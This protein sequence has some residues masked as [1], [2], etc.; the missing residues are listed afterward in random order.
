MPKE[1]LKSAILWLIK[2]PLL[3][4]SR[5]YRNSS[6]SPEIAVN[7]WRFYIGICLFYYE[8]IRTPFAEPFKAGALPAIVM[9]AM[10]SFFGQGPSA[11]EP[12]EVGER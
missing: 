12:A 6:M 3:A 10:E 7:C 11:A 2:R 5:P 9:S 8:V 1:A 4:E